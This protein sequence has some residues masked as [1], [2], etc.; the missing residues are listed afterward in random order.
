MSN[1]H[2]IVLNETKSLVLAD[3]VQIAGTSQSRRQGLL[4]FTAMPKGFGI[5]IAPC[6][7]VHTFRMR[8]PIDLVFLSRD[9]QVTKVVQAL[10][11]WRIAV[12]FRS[13]SVLEL[14]A[15]TIDRTRTLPGDRLRFQ[16]P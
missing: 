5:W 6:E 13:H 9:K 10:R 16:T 1:D 12:S 15:G 2:F 7:A 4:S 3:R 14:E 11:P 8:F